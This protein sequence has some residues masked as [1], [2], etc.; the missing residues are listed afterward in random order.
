MT[1]EELKAWR[2]RPLTDEEAMALRKPMILYTDKYEKVSLDKKEI[3]DI[4]YNKSKSYPNKN[5]LGDFIY[6]I[7]THA[8]PEYSIAV[9][10]IIPTHS[11]TKEYDETGRK[12]IS[13]NYL[14]SLMYKDTVVLSFQYDKVFTCDYYPSYYQP[15]QSGFAL[16]VNPYSQTKPNQ[17]EK[18]WSTCPG[19][20]VTIRHEPNGELQP[21]FPETS[22]FL[23]NVS[24]REDTERSFEEKFPIINQIG[25]LLRHYDQAS[26]DNLPKSNEYERMADDELKELYAKSS[27]DLYFDIKSLWN[28]RY[29]DK[30][31]A[32]EPLILEQEDWS[33]DEWTVL[34]KLFNIPAA[35]RIKIS[36]YRLEFFGIDCD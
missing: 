11:K 4:I 33:D 6:Y 10:K 35:T 23:F 12:V 24:E 28:G 32:R 1:P 7:A 19:N 8:D 27:I 13:F 15:I 16:L 18:V 36:G 5:E 25:E 34:L 31:V 17:L 21:V 30:G 3:I 22:L 20:I 14:I 2:K 26:I 29:I 9:F